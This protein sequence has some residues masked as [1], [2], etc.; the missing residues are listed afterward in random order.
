MDRVLI[1]VDCQVDFMPG[2]S[3]AVPNGDEI[4]PVVNELIR[5]GKYYSV[6]FTKDWHPQDHTSFASNNGVAPFTLVGEEMKW[7]DHCVEDTDGA[8]I[9]KDI[10]I[11]A[12]MT[13]CYYAT[14]YKGCNPNVEEYSALSDHDNELEIAY[15]VEGYEVDVVGL[16]TEYC[17]FHTAKDLIE[18]TNAKTVNFL[19]YGMRHITEDGKNEAIK[20]LKEIGVNIIETK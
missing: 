11:P 2:G 19:L 3:L 4:V 15:E 5:S 18:K 1:C 16:A 17:C 10:T 8:K 12:D 6:I 20:Q 9:H 14:L 13:D 7:T